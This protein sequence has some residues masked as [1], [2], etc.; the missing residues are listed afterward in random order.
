MSTGLVVVQHF[1]FALI[2]IKTTETVMMMCKLHIG[3]QSD[4]GP[5]QNYIRIEANLEIK[6]RN[7]AP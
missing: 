5:E 6:A 3:Y 1:K 2:V 7:Q 4:Y